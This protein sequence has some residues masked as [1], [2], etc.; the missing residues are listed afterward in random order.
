ML[1][2]VISEEGLWRIFTSNIFLQHLNFL[3]MTLHFTCKQ[4]NPNKVKFK[5]YNLEYLRKLPHL[6]TSSPV[7]ILWLQILPGQN[8]MENTRTDG[9]DCQC[10]LQPRFTLHSLSAPVPT[11]EACH[12]NSRALNWH[13]LWHKN[14]T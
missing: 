7:Y 9:Y 2:L 13:L 8:S 6:I 11:P 14:W 12:L 5:K 10:L 3:I 4:T 1:I